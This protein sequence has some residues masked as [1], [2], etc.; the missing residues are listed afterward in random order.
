MIVGSWDT[1]ESPHFGWL[2][3]RQY[4]G[5]L[6]PKTPSID[7]C[8]D[9]GHIIDSRDARQSQYRIIDCQHQWEGALC[10]A[11]CVPTMP[12]WTDET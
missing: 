6:I 5:L 12:T 2:L 8:K 3:V 9:H 10:S 4:D 1:L 11:S 7:F